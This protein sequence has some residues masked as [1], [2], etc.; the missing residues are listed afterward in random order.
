M[1]PPRCPRCTRSPAAYQQTSR[2]QTRWRR[3]LSRPREWTRSSRSGPR[4][5][6]RRCPSRP[7]PST[8]DRI[9][10]HVKPRHPRRVEIVLHLS[11][12]GDRQRPPVIQRPGQVF[13]AGSVALG[14]PRKQPPRFLPTTQAFSVIC[15]LYIRTIAQSSRFRNTEAMQTSHTAEVML[16]RIPCF[17]LLRLFSHTAARARRSR[18]AP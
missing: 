14:Q 17:L 16:P 12:A 7:P 8:T 3:C 11:A 1:P 18:P 2:R 9:C 10:A 5:H 6:C 13:S 15:H 4:T